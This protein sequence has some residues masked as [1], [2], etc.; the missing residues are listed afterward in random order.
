VND[1]AVWGYVMDDWES[2]NPH[3][4]YNLD[5]LLPLARDPE[6]LV[7]RLDMMFTHGMLSQRTRE[8]IK[9]AVEPL[10]SGDYREDRVRLALYL[11]MISPDYNIMK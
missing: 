4:T 7:N 2:D 1:W 3:V 6:V 10:I 5:E 11:I 9:D 8:I